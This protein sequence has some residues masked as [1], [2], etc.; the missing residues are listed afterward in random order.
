MNMKLLI[1]DPQHNPLQPF[2]SPFFSLIF[3]SFFCYFFHIFYFFTNSK[4]QTIYEGCG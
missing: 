3:S 1:T 2:K 4:H